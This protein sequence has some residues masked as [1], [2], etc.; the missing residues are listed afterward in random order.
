MKVDSPNIV[1]I[2]VDCLRPDHL[3]CY[4]YPRNTSPNINALASKGA[5]FLQAI[6]NGGQTPFAFPCILASTL[7]IL[8]RSEVDTPLRHGITIAE[9]LKQNGYYTAAFHDNV[10]IS[11]Y[12]G[13]NRG[14]DIFHDSPSQFGLKGTRAMMVRKLVLERPDSMLTKLVQKLHA[15]LD[16]ILVRVQSRPVATADEITSKAISSPIIGKEKF[17]LWLHYMDVHQPYM[18]PAKYVKQICSRPIG[19]AEMRVL[20]HKQVSEPDKVL[21]SEVETIIDLYDANVKCVD[22]AIGHLLNNLGDDLDNTIIIITADHGGE[23]GEHAEFFH[24]TLY[25]TVIRVPLI[26]VGPGIKAGTLV[27][28]QVSLINLAP[29]IADIA[30]IR[31]PSG[32]HGKSLLPVMSGAKCLPT[33]TISTILKPPPGVKPAEYLMPRGKHLGTEPGRRSL[34][35]R[36]LGWKYIHTE[37]L[38]S[39][40]DVIGQELYNLRNDPGETKNLHGTDAEEARKFEL[41]AKN[42]LSQFKKFK[43]E[44]NTVYEKERLTAKLRKLGKM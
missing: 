10:F 21:P 18:P 14:F 41:E 11:R 6:S 39:K 12:Y 20:Y 19:R 1:L 33:A 34:S 4:N 2:T 42:K 35:Y 40:E 17:F 3:G 28:D 5:L 31:S 16:P 26:M 7:P 27:Q 37:R 15:L 8:D 43:T 13:Y 25:D 29:T 30:G 32:F 36:T 9:L 22:D 23:L 24:Q 44:R 38:D